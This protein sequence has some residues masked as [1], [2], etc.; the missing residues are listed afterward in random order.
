MLKAGLQG[1]LAQPISRRENRPCCDL[2]AA[3]GKW[4]LHAR[5][6]PNVPRTVPSSS[7][8]IATP[9]FFVERLIFGKVPL[10]NAVLGEDGQNLP[11]LF[12]K[13]I[14]F[15]HC[16]LNNKSSSLPSVFTFQKNI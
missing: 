13:E 16:E 12:Y 15:L 5:S 4:R 2:S 6:G 7:T 1:E 10:H 11:I 9:H 8:R 14:V 3:T